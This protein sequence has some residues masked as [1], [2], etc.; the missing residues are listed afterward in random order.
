MEDLG[1]VYMVHAGCS[2]HPQHHKFEGILHKEEE[3]G[4]LLKQAVAG[5][6]YLK[7]FSF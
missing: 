3:E 5:L 2:M 7:R 4:C 1:T 6:G